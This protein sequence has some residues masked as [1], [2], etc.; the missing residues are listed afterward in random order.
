VN[1]LVA[2]RSFASLRAA[3]DDLSKRLTTIRVGTDDKAAQAALLRLNAQTDALAKK[4]IDPTVELKGADRVQAQILTISA[5]MDKLSAKT[6]TPNVDTKVDSKGGLLSRVGSFVTSAGGL[7]PG[8]G[9]AGGAAGGAGGAAGGGLPLLPGIG[10]LSG[11]AVT[12]GAAGIVALFASGIGGIV[13]L[14]TAATLGVGAFGALAIPTFSK[15]KDSVTKI[16]AD[17]LAYNDALTKAQQSTAAKKLAQDWAA[18]NGPQTAA[19]KG[20]QSLESS[21]GRLAAKLAPDVFKVF[22]DGLRAANILLPFLLPLA[23]ASAGAIDGLVKNLGRFAQSAGFRDF[24]RQ[25]S[26]LAGPAIAAIGEGIGR[27]AVALGKFI[28]ALLSPNGI[29]ALTGIFSVLAGAFD[30]LSFLFIN[31]LPV[32]ERYFHNF[33]VATD[34]VRGAMKTLTL[35]VLVTASTVLTGF[36]IMTDGVLGFI[37]ATLHGAADAFGWVP[38]LGGKLRAA[39]AA[40][41][42]F[43][44]GVDKNLNSAIGTVNK[45]IGALNLNNSISARAARQIVGDFAAQQKSADKANGALATYDETIRI[46]GV[47]SNAA[48]RDRLNLI[49]DM[50]GAGV[51]AATAKTDVGA[52]TAAVRDNGV[53]SQ[54][55]LQAR[56]K[57]VSDIFAAHV[58]A[59]RG[60]TDLANYTTAVRDNGAKSDA[61]KSARAKLIT[62]LE[63]AGLNAQRAN[64]LV[65]GLTTGIGRIP[66]SKSVSIHVS[67]TGNWSI[68]QSKNTNFGSGLLAGTPF[69]GAAGGI[70]P[71][72]KPG[73]D[74]EWARVSPGEAILVPELVRAIG[75]GPILAANRAYAGGRT[76]QGMAFAGGGLVAGNF[77]G[78]A[79]WATG[80]YDATVRAMVTQVGQSIA[81][82]VNSAVSN[83][84]SAGGPAGKGVPGTSAQVRAWILAALSIAGKPASWLNGMEVM[85]SK[86]SG[87]NPL[88]ANRTAAGIA[89]G[90]PEGI[91]QTVIG[92]F[93]LYSLPGHKNIWNPIDDLIASARYIGDRWRSPYN[94]PGITGGAYGGYAGGG[95]IMEPIAGVGLQTGRRYGFGEAGPETVTPG[96]GGDGASTLAE[97]RALRAAVEALP[98]RIAAGVAAGVAAP[99]NT[100]AQAARLG[101]R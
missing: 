80:Q 45:W 9:G 54:Q 12:A 88:A 70:I 5:A 39:S 26:A 19:V 43:K 100:A 66:G 49:N 21:F 2:Q 87:G 79:P 41:D 35:A 53:G 67:G 40:F 52:Y 44:A 30:G 64:D 69:A 1:D 61:A 46:Q 24:I 28:L 15:V 95:V 31:G 37:G 42:G 77:A 75:A 11:G 96:I 97:L 32:M 36:K 101:A 25:M 78:L 81:N 27:V 33:A 47:T 20:V 85:V 59:Q 90:S 99:A 34:I 50:I 89:A 65:N 73:V 76:S 82:A 29:R 23:T 56:E 10:G 16:A 72:Y 98:G 62:D 92:T 93:A 68:S 74:S 13:P 71:G 22:N 94:I 48:R 6:A 3:S 86:E 18:L 55:A 51:K 7:I 58:N 14:L 60:K 17:Q 8:S 84:L 4:L 63:H 57:L 38:G 83:A 91:A